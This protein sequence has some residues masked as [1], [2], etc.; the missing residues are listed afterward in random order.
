MKDVAPCNVV[1]QLAFCNSTYDV[2]V[3]PPGLEPVIPSEASRLLGRMES[4][5]VNGHDAVSCRSTVVANMYDVTVETD[6][7]LSAE[8]EDTTFD[9]AAD[10]PSPAVIA[11]E[12]LPPQTADSDSVIVIVTTL[13]ELWSLKD[14]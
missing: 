2:T 11:L 5:A 12:T 7:Q 13:P 3:T 1:A 8:K 14:R 4:E 9:V 6:A 10:V